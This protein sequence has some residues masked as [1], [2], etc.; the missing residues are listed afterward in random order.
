MMFILFL[1]SHLM[2]SEIELGLE[3]ERRGCG[4]VTWGNSINLTYFLENCSRS[5]NNMINI[6]V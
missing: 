6:A 2:E 4:G 5:N 1:F 3:G